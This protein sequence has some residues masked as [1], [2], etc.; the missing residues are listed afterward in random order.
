MRHWKKATGVILSLAM[1]TAMA[2]ISFAQDNKAASNVNVAGESGNENPSAISRSSSET[3]IPK[4]RLSVGKGQST[5]NYNAEQKVELTVKIV[6]EGSC[7][8]NNVKISPVI[9]NASDFPFKIENMNEEKTIEQ[10]KAGE[11]AEATWNFSVRADVETKSYKT[12]FQITYDDGT[13]I[14]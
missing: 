13:N 9:D 3:P 2:P 1:L 5:P 4:I 6:N 7:D 14:Y 10:I 11:S 12:P 8:A